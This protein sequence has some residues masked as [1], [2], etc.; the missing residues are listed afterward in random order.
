MAGG[1]LENR[2]LENRDFGSTIGNNLLE[3]VFLYL[4]GKTQ[5]EADSR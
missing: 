4:Y 1:V 3:T 2:V 5:S